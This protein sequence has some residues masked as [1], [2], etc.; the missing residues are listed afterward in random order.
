MLW[1]CHSQFTFLETSPLP[2]KIIIINNTR[3]NY[4][5]LNEGYWPLSNH[6]RTVG[7]EF[8][9]CPKQRP[10]LFFTPEASH[11]NWNKPL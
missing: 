3:L 4:N 1:P 8:F 7:C 2:T 6:Y 11:K 9:G 5:M 10:K